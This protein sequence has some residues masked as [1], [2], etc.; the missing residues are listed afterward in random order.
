MT[1]KDQNAIKYYI[2]ITSFGCYNLLTRETGGAA[3]ELMTEV[4]NK[5]KRNVL[6]VFKTKDFKK[7]IPL[8]IMFIPVIAFYICFKYLPMF[9]IVMAFQNFNIGKGIFGSEFV[10]LKY[11]ELIFT[12]GATLDVIKNTL[13]LGLTRFIIGMPFPILIALMLNEIKHVGFKKMT[14]TL[15]Y[16]PHFLSWTIVGGMVINL[17]SQE[18]GFINTMYEAVTGNTFPFLYRPGSWMAIYFGTGIWKETG[19]AAIIYLAALT[20]ID[21][22]LYDAASI[23]GASKIKQMLHVTIPAITPTIIVNMILSIGGA[24]N[25]GFDQIYVMANPTVNSISDVIS[26]YVYRVGLQQMQFSLTSAMGLFQ[27][28]LGLILVIM[29]NRLAKKADYNLW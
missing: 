11:F 19:F 10:G 7:S 8:F 16:L 25:V 27:S 18:T 5:K 14:Q 6:A 29:T 24:V 3:L 17:F 15:I 23:D 2:L 28:V 20:S 22:E 1:K 4:Q 21:P 12:N 13:V 26:T 9:G